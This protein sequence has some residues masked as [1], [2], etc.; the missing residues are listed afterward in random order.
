MTGKIKNL[1]PIG[2]SNAFNSEMAYLE[3]RIEQTIAWLPIFR[4]NAFIEY[5]D[6]SDSNMASSK[7]LRINDSTY[8]SVL[9]CIDQFD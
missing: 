8:I 2:F 7:I 9:E 4:L 5:E 6:E 1:E 3:C